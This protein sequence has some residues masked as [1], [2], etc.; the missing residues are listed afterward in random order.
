MA[1]AHPGATARLAEF[2]QATAYDDIPA[3]VIRRAKYCLLDWIGSAYA[4]LGHASGRIVSEVIGEMG[5]KPAATLIG[6][7]QAA[8]PTAA[9]L[10]NGVISAVVELDDVHE[11]A[12]L[13]PSIGVIPAALAVAEYAGASGKAFLEAVV[14][15]YD[16]SARTARAAGASHYQFWHTTGT[17]NTFG[18]AAAAGKLLRL[19]VR[20]MTMALGLA[21]TQA[22]GLWESLNAD[23]TM[24]K[25][26][27]SGKAASTGVLSALL[28][29]AG[30]QASET[31]LE[32]AKGFLTSSSRA[33]E[34]DRARLTEKLGE[35]FLIMRS[36]F[37]RYA[38]CRACF[39]GIEGVRQ[40][41]RA[42]GLPPGAVQKI[43]VTMKPARTWLVANTDPRDIYQAKFSLPFCMAVMALHHEA[44]PSEFTEENLRDPAIRAFMQK[45]LLANDPAIASKA[46]IELVDANRMVWTAEPTCQSP[47]LEEVE[48]K[49][50]KNMSPLLGEAA[51]RGL[52]TTVEHLEEQADLAELSRLLTHPVSR[53]I[54]A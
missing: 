27:H 4:G 41:L 38:C 49:F 32:G 50:I 22:S 42:H 40:L 48:E 12:S 25:H 46:R 54:S 6:S 1:S 51:V 14:L 3:E 9:A 13:H 52:L 43:T 35:P 10:Y 31:I 33:T 23:A 7:R 2:I 19:D 5:G 34:E 36:F 45:V 15:G 18:A 11:E 17:C 21:G 37:K 39:E 8:P 20:A 29:R 53:R 47:N 30:F 28:A 16:L 24:A 44:G 26:L